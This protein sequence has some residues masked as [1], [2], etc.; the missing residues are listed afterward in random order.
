MMNDRIFIN[1]LSFDTIIGVL[2]QERTTPQ[3]I[4]IDLQIE[5]Q[6]GRG[7]TRFRKV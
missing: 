5:L 7:T 2:E 1:E 4:S 3:P 6:T